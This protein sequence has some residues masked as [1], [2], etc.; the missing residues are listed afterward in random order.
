MALMDEFKEERENIKNGTLKQK[1]A[2]FWEYYKWYVIVPVIILIVVISYI[3][4][5]MTKTDDVLNGLLINAKSVEAQTLADQLGADF[6]KEMKIDTKEYSVS[7][8]TSLSYMA[9]NPSGMTNY[10][11]S[12][13]LMAWIGAGA[14]DFINSDANT[15]TELAYR[16]YFSDLRD[17][18]SEDNLTQYEPYFL[19]IDQA[20]IDAR[21]DS[22][23]N[24]QDADTIT[25]PDCRKPETMEKPV[26]VLIDM[27]QCKTL[28]E[29]YSEKDTLA[30]GI[31]SNAPNLDMTLNFLKY[32]MK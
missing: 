12:Q 16:E 4:H 13:A 6:S 23:E 7:L 11:T 9:N 5:M 17:V 30:L 31:V 21:N 28:T 2:Y 25:L 26:P 8:N 32:L 1:T 20:V 3:H 19:Y 14:V 29:L 24:N 27:S 22:L 10:E 18:L 15:M